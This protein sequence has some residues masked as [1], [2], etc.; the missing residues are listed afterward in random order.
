[1]RHG[2]TLSDYMN[3]LE[4]RQAWAHSSPEVWAR[5]YRA[6]IKSLSSLL[7]WSRE[8]YPKQYRTYHF[9]ADATGKET[10]E[11]LWANFLGWKDRGETKT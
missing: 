4:G 7:R 8:N 6:N 11:L 10:M 1:M 5:L 2:V 9:L 3:S